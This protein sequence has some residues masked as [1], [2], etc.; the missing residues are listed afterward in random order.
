LKGQISQSVKLIDGS[1]S[2]I[3]VSDYLFHTNWR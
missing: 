3:Y 1:S 2:Y